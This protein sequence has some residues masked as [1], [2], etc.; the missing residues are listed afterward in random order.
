M[1][2]GPAALLMLT[3][4]ACP[5]AQSPPD[6]AVVAAAEIIPESKVVTDE[7][8]NAWIRYAGFLAAQG[9]SRS[10][11]GGASSNAQVLARALADTEMRNDAGL[12]ESQVD[13]I[14]EMVADFVAA[15]G[16]VKLTGADAMAEFERVAAGMPF[17][18]RKRAE[19]ALAE[20][21]TKAPVQ[22]Q[23][24]LG[25]LYAKYGKPSVDAVVAQEADVTHAWE[26]LMNLNGAP[27]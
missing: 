9:S 22:V 13:G 4:S 12:S 27:K 7:Q 11:D 2:R 14:E 24:S 8:V 23:L 1:R 15:R 6:A 20:L 25:P 26:Q 3:L 17:D 16:T 5:K 19:A 10:V 18:Q 21:K